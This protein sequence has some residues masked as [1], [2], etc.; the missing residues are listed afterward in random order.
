M[1]EEEKKATLEEEQAYK[2]ASPEEQEASEETEEK[3]EETSSAEGGSSTG[4]E[5]KDID[6][7]KKELE[8][9]EAS[10]EKKPKYSH[11]EKV[12]YRAKQLKNELEKIGADP[13]DVFGYKPA[14]EAKPERRDFDEDE[15]EKRIENRLEAKRLARTEDELN[16]I[17]WY[18]NNRGLSVTDAHMLA[19]K[20]RIQSFISEQKRAQTTA[21]K[22]TNATGRKEMRD[23]SPRLP[24]SDEQYLLNK[25]FTKNADGSFEGKK[26]KV[27]FDKEKNDWIS[28]KK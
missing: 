27:F 10:E 2:G 1:T 12:L 5:E 7:H 19:N 22:G 18:V 6:Y 14:E 16:L 13:A 21:P 4:G 3:T 25:G 15:V 28:V 20:G 23:K 11:K 26:T 17:L 24:A 8:K 9:L